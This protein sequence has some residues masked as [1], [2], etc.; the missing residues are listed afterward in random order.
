MEERQE[1][2]IPGIIEGEKIL[3]RVPSEEYS[4]EKMGAS[5]PK[6]PDEIRVVYHLYRK[7]VP[8]FF[9]WDTITQETLNAAIVKLEGATNKTR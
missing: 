1:L 9:F 8:V 3:L 5:Y 4:I 6:T 2:E 7:G